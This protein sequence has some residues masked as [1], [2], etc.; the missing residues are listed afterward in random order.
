MFMRLILCF[1]DF[2]YFT[3]TILLLL[4]LLCVYVCVFREEGEEEE[5]VFFILNFRFLIFIIYMCFNSVLKLFYPFWFSLNGGFFLVLFLTDYWLDQFW[6]LT[7]S[8][9]SKNTLKTVNTKIFFSFFIG[10]CNKI[11][12]TAVPV[13]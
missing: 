12:T 10:Y 7:E 6:C 2:L 11:L 8:E 13:Q 3:T 9:F 4:L 1:T 5:E